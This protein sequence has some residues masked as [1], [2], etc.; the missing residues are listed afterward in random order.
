M[1]ILSLKAATGRDAASLE[2]AALPEPGVGEVRVALKAAS[3]NHRELWI[4]RGMYPGMRLPATLGCDGAGVIDAVGQGIDAGR[5]GDEVLLYPGLNWGPDP[6]YPGP[7]FGLLGMPGPGTIADAICLPAENAVPK[8][9]HLDFAAAAAMPLGALTA[10]RG[11]VTKGGLK[12]GDKLLVTGI[13]G[14]VATF[15]LK[16]GV[17]M[18][19]DVYVTSGSEATL[20]AATALGAKGAINYKRDKWGKTLAQLSGGIDLVFDAAPAGGYPQYG[21]A[22]NMGAR[23][24]VY[25]ST[26]GQQFEISAPELFLKNIQL[27]GTNVGNLAE[28]RAMIAFVGQ[29]RIEP[30][31]E[32]RFDIDDVEA[33]LKHLE[34]S[35]GFG[36]IVI[37]IGE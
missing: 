37:D 19:A 6:L 32:T 4:C 10:W 29:K 15:A 21:R 7:D 18:G 5:I 26:G 13:G 36:K 23:V 2:T 34:E 27:I 17:A 33:A 30:V 14:G 9:A 31:I 24:V 25:G 1:R 12:P 22:L 35:H 11:L 8:P 20:A 3:L 28:F 16:F